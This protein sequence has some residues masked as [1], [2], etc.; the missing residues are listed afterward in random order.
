PTLPRTPQS[1]TSSELRALDYSVELPSAKYNFGFKVLR[2]SGEPILQTA[3]GFVYSDQLLQLSTVIPSHVLYGLGEHR[4]DLMINTTWTRI[5]LWNRDHIPQENTNLYGSHPFYVCKDATGWHGVFLQ[6]SNAMEVIVQPAPAVTWRTIGGNFDFYVFLGSSFDSVVSQYVSLVGT[7]FLPP[8]WALGFHLC[9]QYY[10]TANNTLK[11]MDRLRQY[12]I[13]QDVQ[14]NDI[15][16]AEGG[17]VYTTDVHTFGDQAGLAKEIHARSMHYIIMVD[18]GISNN[19]T[20]GTYLP[21]DLGVKLGIFINGSDGKPLVGRVWP[22]TT[23]WPD[24]LHP[25]A[26]QYWTEIAKKFHDKVPFDGMWVDMNE[27][28]NFIDGSINGCDPKSSYDNPPYLPAVSGGNLYTKTICPSAQH[29]ISSHYNIHNIYGYFETYRSNRAL[30]QLRFKRPFV[31]SRSTFSG[32]GHY[33]GHWSGDNAATFY[34][35]YKSISGTMLHANMYGI[36]VTGSD[37]CG[38]NGNTT[39]ELCTRWHQ[40]GAFYTFSRNHNSDSSVAQDPGQFGPES[41]ASTRKA[42]LTRYSLLPYLYTLMFK[43]HA[44]GSTVARP[45][46]FEF[47]DDKTTYNLDSQFMWGPALMISPVLKENDRSVLAYFPK[48]RWYDFYSGAKVEDTGQ[49]VRLDAPLDVI[50]LHVRGGHVL[51][52]QPPGLTTAISRTQPFWLLVVLDAA[53]NA[54]G[55]IFFDDGDSI[56]TFEQGLYNWITFSA[57][58]AG[59]VNTVKHSNFTTE[60]MALSNITV[61]GLEQKPSS[62]MLNGYSVYFIYNNTVRSS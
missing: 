17:R 59:L 58:K 29:K 9:W 44:L 5:V 62:V 54:N 2:R 51:P 55:E 20:P 60:P 19:A 1:D 40:L 36:S 7:T 13:P 57:T 12:G 33:G 52:M 18:C 39:A 24:F 4:Q 56:D 42:L 32:Q 34:D 47:P 11:T 28:S 45:L 26:T 48:D 35:M 38:F 21:Y 43:S 49:H 30:K 50:N 15:D 53:E 10:G 37:I 6:N 16:Y 46:V 14:W 41:A 8:Y 3:G 27:I 31:I 22:G 61:F 23:V 25:A